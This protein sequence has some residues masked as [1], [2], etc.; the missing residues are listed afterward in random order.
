[1]T[2]GGVRRQVAAPTPPE[3]PTARVQE[4]RQPR[5]R[6]R[7]VARAAAGILLLIACYA[8]G[9]FLAGWL[10]LPVPGS[11]IGMVIMFVVLCLQPAQI[12]DRIV[13]PISEKLVSLIPFLLVPAAV[14][15]VAHIPEVVRDAPALI[16]AVVGGWLAT[17]L[18][19][20]L[21]A[22]YLLGRIRRKG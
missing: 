3:A 18:V 11:V 12:S 9:E 6:V 2:G 10:R 8:S 4:R 19:T 13:V 1:M 14:G 15:I 20:A 7:T 17:I 21:A 22:K 5:E 16:T